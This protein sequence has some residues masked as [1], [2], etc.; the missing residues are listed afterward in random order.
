MARYV[1]KGKWLDPRTGTPMD[2]P[3]R[4]GLCMPAVH[5]D[6]ED[7]TS[8]IDGSVVKSRTGQ[9]YDLAKNGC[10]LKEQPFKKMH[11][12]EYKE[13]KARQAKALEARR[14]AK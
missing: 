14:A 12:E 6:I 13:H 10:V 7:Y 8:P 9:R 1:W 5:S 3:E 2:I 4:D 11:P